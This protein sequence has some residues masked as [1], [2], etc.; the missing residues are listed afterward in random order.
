MQI[1]RKN[2]YINDII[3]TAIFYFKMY[4][5]S[6][7]NFKNVFLENLYKTHHFEKLK[8]RNTC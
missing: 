8:K 2:T 5:F 4:D 1:K 6:Y 7:Q 3:K